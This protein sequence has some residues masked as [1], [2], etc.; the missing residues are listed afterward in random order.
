MVDWYWGMGLRVVFFGPSWFVVRGACPF[1]VYRLAHCVHPT[2]AGL[3][4]CGWVGGDSRCIR[5]DDDDGR[6]DQ[7]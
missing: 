4:G 1:S 2:V 5:D 6:R 3:G 7:P